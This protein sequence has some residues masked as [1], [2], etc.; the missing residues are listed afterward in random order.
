MLPWSLVLWVGA[1]ALLLLVNARLRLNLAYVA[2]ALWGLV[3]VVIQQRQSPLP[4]SDA[5]AL[6]AA[7]LAAALALHA[8]VLWLQ[9]PKRPS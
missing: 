9:R 3:G 4:G 8:G 2:A 1:G 6:V 7:A 5:S